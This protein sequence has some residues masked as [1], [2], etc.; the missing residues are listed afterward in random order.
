[1][2]LTEGQ[3]RRLGIAVPPLPRRKVPAPPRARSVAE[4]ALERQLRSSGLT[5]WCTEHRFDQRR[6]WRLDFAFPAEQLAVEVDGGVHRTKERFSG[7]MDKHNALTLAGWKTLRFSA[8]HIATGM[9]I[10]AIRAAL[11]RTPSES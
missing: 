11:G 10:E 7:D 6:R 4:V 2:R 5:G 9:A 1:M 3:A 8:K